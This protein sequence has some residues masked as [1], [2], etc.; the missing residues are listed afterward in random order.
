[1]F[2]VIAPG[3]PTRTAKTRET[4]STTQALLGAA[5]ACFLLA[6]TAGSINAWTVASGVDAGL[7]EGIAGLALSAAAATG[8]GLRIYSGTRLDTN[9]TPPF[10][11]AARIY[12][13]GVAGMALLAFRVPGLHVIA[14]LMAFGGG[15]IWPAFTNYAI[16][17]A[18]PNSA[19]Q[20]TGMTQTG[21]YIGVM[22]APVTT[23]VIIDRVGYPVMWMVVACVGVAAGLSLAALSPQFTTNAE[24]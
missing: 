4:E 16:V 7:S 9:V 2:F 10:A 18:N 15:W 22:S 14:A 21:V 23:G 11:M 24:R 8:I 12:V 13:I 1:M 3:T 20:A 17:G 5:V 6:F 19:A